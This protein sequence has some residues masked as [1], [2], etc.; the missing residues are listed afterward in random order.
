[1]RF[2][3]TA[4]RLGIVS[5]TATVVLLVGFAATLAVG[6]AS[7]ESPRQPIGD[8]LFTVLEILIILV[9]PA[10]VALMAAVHAWAPADAKTLRGPPSSSRVCS[11]G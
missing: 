11:P 7:L 4:R 2:T 10:M 9:M 1:M 5:A 3:A 8:P 6:L